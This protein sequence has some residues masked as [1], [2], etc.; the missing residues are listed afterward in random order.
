MSFTWPPRP[1]IL[2]GAAALPLLYKARATY[3]KPVPAET[4]QA[5][6]S[7]E[8]GVKRAAASQIAFRALAT[9][10]WA[11]FGTA[12]AVLS[13]ALVGY[14]TLDAALHDTRRLGRATLAAVGW[15]QPRHED[16]ERMAN[17]TEEE[18]VQ[19]VANTYFGEWKE[20]LQKDKNNNISDDKAA[21]DD[22]S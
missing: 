2:L 19:Y 6:K 12:A 22:A 15:E 11:S 10:T 21:T 8:Q 16:F 17:M 20:P 13:V 7:V 14:P 18:E 5:L 4:L 9:A 3:N 1:S